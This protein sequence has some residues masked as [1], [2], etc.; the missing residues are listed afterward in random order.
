MFSMAHLILAGK[1]LLISTTGYVLYKLLN[2]LI[3]A[4]RTKNI[5]DEQAFIIFRLLSRWLL[6]I[7]SLLLIFQQFGIDASRIF[8]ALSAVFV[9]MAVGFVAVWSVLSNILCSFL[10]LIFPPFRFGDEIEI[11]EADKDV[12]IKGKVIAL[13]LFFTT[14]ENNDEPENGKLL[15]K[16]PNTMF[17]QRVIACHEGKNTQQLKL[18][19]LQRNH[20]EQ[21]DT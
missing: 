3:E 15:I 13:S 12:G 20:G 1:I 9:I 19:P 16:I 5:V 14:L 21:T 8:T 18:K 11:R 7:I 6:I 4:L 2:R 17:F 10:L